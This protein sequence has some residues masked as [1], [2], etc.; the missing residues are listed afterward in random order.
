MFK[1][2]DH[3]GIAVSSLK[4]AISVYKNL[5]LKVSRAENVSGMGVRVAFI[6]VGDVRLELLEP[7]SKDSVVAKFI[8]QRG[9]GVHHICIEVDDLAKI[10][11]KLQEKNF[12]LVYDKPQRGADQSLISFVHPKSTHGILL[13]LSEKNK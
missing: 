12:R 6:S 4:T 7:L 10:L 2:I 9:E 8:E 11:K 13:E 5:G 3:I 1:K